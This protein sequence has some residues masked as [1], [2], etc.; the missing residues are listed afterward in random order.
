VTTA[1]DDNFCVAQNAEPT[2]DT[3][4]AWG[5]E[6]LAAI[7]RDFWLGDRGFYAESMGGQ[8]ESR[9]RQP[10][11]MWSAGVQL[12]A[13]AAAAE[14]DED[15]YRQQLTEYAGA[16][17]SYWTES[18]GRKGYDVQPAAKTTDRY[19]D[20]NAWLV[21]ALVEAWE[22]TEDRQYFDRAV[23]TFKFVLSGQD[24]QL[25]GGIFW[26]E[27]RRTTKNTCSNAS[28]IVA[29]L[30]LFQATEQPQHRATATRLYDWTRK[31][32]QDSDGLYWDNIALN[33]AVDRRKYSYNSAMM[34]R[35]NCSF[36]EL[37]R[38]EHYLKEA[39]RIGRAAE[40]HWVEGDSG[41]IHDAGKF[42]HMLLEAFL[43]IGEQDG[44][45]RWRTLVCRSLCYVH[46]QLRDANGRYP[47]RWD[48]LAAAP[49]SRWE[50]IDQA[51]AAR[52]YFA[53]VRTSSASAPDQISV[54]ADR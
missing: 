48:R 24:G 12:T 45:A 3:L 43:A 32:L 35:A 14:I 4:R 51:S 38:E 13:L 42:A 34:I 22:T 29:A 41:A 20:D 54:P 49:L 40:N 27:N 33:G 26:R 31:N 18:D 39:Q 1:V 23:E 53:A 21:L 17:Q 52:A 30:R 9:H 5:D 8:R 10:A 16:L 44:D 2:A 7:R 11:Y 47:G 36:Y 15:P 19:Y 50:L 25:G 46:D 37:T 28:T 6:S